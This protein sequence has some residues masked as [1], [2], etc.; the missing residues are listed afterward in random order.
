M[1]TYFS[2]HQTFA[3]FLERGGA[4]CSPP[5]S[6]LPELG[7]VI[8]AA[9]RAIAG[10][11][12][13]KGEVAWDRCGGGLRFWIICLG[14]WV[15]F[16]MPDAH[17]PSLAYDLVLLGPETKDQYFAAKQNIDHEKVGRVV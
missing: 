4:Q 15:T 14:E 11:N 2:F 5:V 9:W 10:P 6:L 13:G 12:L 8:A 3:V 17:S 7:S 1:L 16:A